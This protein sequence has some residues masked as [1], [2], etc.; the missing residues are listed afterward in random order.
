MNKRHFPPPPGFERES[1]PPSMEVGE[2]YDLTPPAE[3][4]AGRFRRVQCKMAFPDKIHY[5]VQGI[6]EGGKEIKTFVLKF[7]SEGIRVTPSDEQK[8]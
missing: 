6:P 5:Q 2:F 1:R 4:A 7:T 8:F 3:V